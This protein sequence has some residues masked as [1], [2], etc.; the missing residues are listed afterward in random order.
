[1]KKVILVDDQ[2]DRFFQN[3]MLACES[4]CEFVPTGMVSDPD[5][6]LRMIREHPEV[7]FIL[8]DGSFKKGDCLEVVAQLTEDER[9]KIICYSTVSEFWKVKL[10]PY[11]VRHF[12]D[13]DIDF[14]QCVEGICSCA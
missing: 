2:Y 4:V 8:L 11:G 10:S 3:T 12:R 7:D 9:R 5:E 13:K 6:A 1:M 14:V